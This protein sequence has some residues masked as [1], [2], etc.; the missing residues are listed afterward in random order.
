MHWDRDRL[1]F[2]PPARKADAPEDDTFEA[3][4]RTYYESIFNP[5][6]LNPGVM[7]THMAKKYWK[8]LPEAQSIPQLVRSAPLRVQQMIE[9]EQAV[10]RKRDPQ[11]AVA[12]MGEAA[13]KYFDRPQ[14]PD[15][16]VAAPGPGWYRRC[17]G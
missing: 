6:R 11:K 3:G 14:P 5:A 17:A 2:G 13:P 8:N 1:T 9:Q 4:W 15:P 12:A 10:P 16:V 7:R